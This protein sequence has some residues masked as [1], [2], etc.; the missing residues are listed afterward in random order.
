MRRRSC[1]ALALRELLLVVALLTVAFGLMVSLA[2]RVRSEAAHSLVQA[3]LLELEDAL[4]LY[5][6]EYGALP[7]VTPLVPEGPDGTVL[8]TLSA[9]DE[10][11]L[12]ARALEQ[13]RALVRIL[14]VG[15]LREDADSPLG[16]VSAMMFDGSLLLDP[17]GGAI[18]YL[19]AGRP[20]IGTATGDAPF[21]FSAGPDG[22]FL[23]RHDNFYSYEVRAAD[24]LE[25]ESRTASSS[26]PPTRRTDESR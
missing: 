10:P 7:Q 20:E 26:A 16:G 2:R 21:F 15:A 11:R 8:A 25:L 9:E 19:P 3:E 14:G 6:R 1:H 5:V 22:L 13:N 17:W 4:A 23:T 12:A 24:A 18:A